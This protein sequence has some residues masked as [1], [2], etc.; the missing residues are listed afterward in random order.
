MSNLRL[1]SL[2]HS[3]LQTKGSGLTLSGAKTLVSE[4]SHMPPNGSKIKGEGIDL[5]LFE[6]NL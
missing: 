5:P 1:F 6:P 3:E 4:D 2:K